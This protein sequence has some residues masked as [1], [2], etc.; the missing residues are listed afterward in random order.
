MTSRS[1]SNA[2]RYGLPGVFLGLAFA[3]LMGGAGP[4]SIAL[5]QTPAAGRQGMTQEASGTI[6]FTTSGSGSTQFLYIVDTKSQAF[7]VYRIDPNKPDGLVKLEAAR[8]YRFD[9][10]LAQYNNLPPEVSAIES[11]VKSITSSSP[12][13]Q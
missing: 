9:L 3:W 1:L 8:Q 13:R 10:R 7:A 2:L 4:S 11:M 6:A 12:N 5:A